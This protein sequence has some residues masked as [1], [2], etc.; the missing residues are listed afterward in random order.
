[1]A[2]RP[3]IHQ[4]EI[5]ATPDSQAA[6][7]SDLL[8]TILASNAVGFGDDRRTEYW[9]G[10]YHIDESLTIAVPLSPLAYKF[11]SRPALFGDVILTATLQTT[12]NS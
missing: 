9:M 10:Q 6:H 5:D 11:V 7:A 3:Q 1:M 2:T 8:R 12:P 4:P